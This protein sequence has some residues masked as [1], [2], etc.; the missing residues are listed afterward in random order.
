M[1]QRTMKILNLGLHWMYPKILEWFDFLR[2]CLFLLK[3][4]YQIEFRKNCNT[5]LKIK[6][7]IT[8]STNTD[9]EMF[10]LTFWSETNIISSFLSTIIKPQKRLKA[11]GTATEGYGGRSWGSQGSKS[12]NSS[13]KWWAYHLQQLHHFQYFSFDLIVRKYFFCFLRWTKSNKCS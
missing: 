12:K 3:G 2:E 7:S 1:L 4:S 6:S 8:F 10:Q 5:Q 13:S 11:T 9:Y